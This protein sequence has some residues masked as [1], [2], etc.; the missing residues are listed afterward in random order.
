MCS[1]PS[2]VSQGNPQDAT[3]NSH[4]SIVTGCSPPP[5]AFLGSLC[6]VILALQW[7]CQTILDHTCDI[8]HIGP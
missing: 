8:C 3:E 2:F 7:V 6:T 1:G 4:V 5:E